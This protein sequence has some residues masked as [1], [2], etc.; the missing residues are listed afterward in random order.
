MVSSVTKE[1]Y[2]GVLDLDYV[3]QRK[4]DTVEE[5][6]DEDLRNASIPTLVFKKRA[7][8]KQF[9]AKRKKKK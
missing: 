3:N 1:D 7:R 5:I 9:Y 4:K 2:E 6:T 8:R